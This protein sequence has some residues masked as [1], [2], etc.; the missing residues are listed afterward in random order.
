MYVA[1]WSL[2]VLDC[3]THPPPPTLLPIL[4][5]YC[6]LAE[7]Y[8]RIQSPGEAIAAYQEALR[9]DPSNAELAI[10]IGK[11][12]VTTH[13]YQNAIE[14]YETAV[15]NATG[16][17]GAGGGG[18]DAAAAGV[19]VDKA[20][21]QIKLAELYAKLQ[22]YDQAVEVLNR[23]LASSR[24]D[25]K[26]LQSAGAARGHSETPADLVAKSRAVTCLLLLAKVK[27]GQQAMADSIDALSRAQSIQA[28]VLAQ[29]RSLSQDA[30]RRERQQMA[31]I[32]YELG[33]AHQ[34]ARRAA[35]GRGEGKSASGEDKS[36]DGGV[37]SG[38]DVISCFRQALKYDEVHEDALL[39]LARLHL[40]RGE[41]DAC[42]QECMTLLRLN[43]SHED[44]VLIMSDVMQR[45]QD[46][47][48]SI[49]HLQQ[50][51][52]DRPNHYKALDGCVRLCVLECL[53]GVQSFAARKRGTHREREE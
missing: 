34:A 48:A 17:G 12:F 22:M 5:R 37:G 25:L 40:K 23:A 13:D 46:V 20:P 11:A 33:I 10:L 19:G 2:Y 38:S 39:A 27:T 16:R 30:A 29:S 45:K 9:H 24:E 31:S 41:V 49:F 51:L 14:Y 32:C 7:A 43:P 3:L 21:L 18:G 6:L 35:G 52:N 4:R 44:G 50:L 1:L 15:T 53:C 36:G 28:S 47:Q 42:Q 8:L 26:Q